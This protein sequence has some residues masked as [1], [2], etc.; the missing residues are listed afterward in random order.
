MTSLSSQCFT[1]AVLVHINQENQ[2]KRRSK[3]SNLGGK[4]HRPFDNEQKTGGSR[5]QTQLKRFNKII[6]SRLGAGRRGKTRRDLGEGFQEIGSA[7]AK[8]KSFIRK[9]LKKE[10]IAKVVKQPYSNCDNLLKSGGLNKLLILH[11]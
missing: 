9:K 11:R 6:E 1:S 2:Q 8:V 5:W 10:I 7:E 3:R 4:N